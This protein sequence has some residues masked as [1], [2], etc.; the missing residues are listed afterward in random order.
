M[1]E[2]SNSDARTNPYRFGVLEGNHAEDRFSLDLLNS[3]Q[4]SP[5]LR[6]SRANQPH[7]QP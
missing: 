6:S 7:L 3:N 1:A 5:P 4:V 2:I